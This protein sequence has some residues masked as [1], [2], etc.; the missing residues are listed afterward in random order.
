VTNAMRTVKIL[1]INVVLD[2]NVVIN[3]LQCFP[4]VEK[5]HIVVAI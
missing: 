1:A 2:L 4:C 3:F 5:L